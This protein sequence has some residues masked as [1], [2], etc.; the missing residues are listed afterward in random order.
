MMQGIQQPTLPGLEAP[1][2]AE[3]QRFAA[4]RSL[5]GLLTPDML[6]VEVHA[7]ADVLRP[8]YLERAAPEQFFADLVDV[9]GTGKSAVSYPDAEVRRPV[10]VALS[11]REYAVLPRHTRKMGDAVHNKTVAARNDSERYAA[12]K[13]S[14]RYAFAGKRE[15]VETYIGTLSAQRSVLHDLARDA[16]GSNRGLSLEGGEIPLRQKFETFRSVILEDA[17]DAVGVQRGWQDSSKKETARRTIEA[18]MVLLRQNNEH[19]RY[20]ERLNSMLLAYNGA[21]QAVFRS[22]LHELNQRLVQ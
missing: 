7:Y 8:D 3:A 2:P 15:A 5:A 18:R 19:L 1:Q 14:E 20:F 13:R 6:G 12:A 17:L 11:P 9:P 4:R 22:R 10:Y 21:K 16:R